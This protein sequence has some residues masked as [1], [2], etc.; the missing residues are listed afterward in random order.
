MQ[1]GKKL[2]TS[3]I[4]LHVLLV[5]DVQNCLFL[6][7]PEKIIKIQNKSKSARLDF[8]IAMFCIVFLEIKPNSVFRYR[9]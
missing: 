3:I 6:K 5:H 1:Q 8:S 4:L 7:M 2:S 9:K